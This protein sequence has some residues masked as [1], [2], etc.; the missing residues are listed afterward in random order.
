MLELGDEVEGGVTK[1]S[2]DSYR[3]RGTAGRSVVL[4]FSPF[5]DPMPFSGSFQVEVYAAGGSEPLATSP[6]YQANYRVDGYGFTPETDGDYELRLVGLTGV[7]FYSFTFRGGRVVAM[8]TPR[9][10]TF[11]P[12]KVDTLFKRRVAGAESITRWEC[13]FLLLTLLAFILL[14]PFLSTPAHAQAIEAATLLSPWPPPGWP[15]GTKGEVRLVS[16]NDPSNLISVFTFP[17]E[18]DGS[19]TYSLPA[20]LPD[21]LPDDIFTPLT[22][23]YLAF[24]QG[25][26]PVVSPSGVGVAELAFVVYADGEPWGTVEMDEEVQTGVF[27]LEG[28]MIAAVLY[29]RQPV[30]V[31]GG[32]TCPDGS[33]VK[34]DMVLDEGPKL[35]QTR[36]G[37]N[38]TSVSAVLETVSSFDLSQR[39]LRFGSQ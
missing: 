39:P 20:K 31:T 22:P 38:L 24:C 17:I 28:R 36:G 9:A 18:D 6:R 25:L 16:G 7:I 10:Q 26:A 27:T 13:G 35:L 30:K 15:A 23:A 14:T 3:F 33:V 12:S 29:A 34:F 19:V 11:E 8:N 32:G 2:V 21:T 4:A 1:D 5:E 37:G